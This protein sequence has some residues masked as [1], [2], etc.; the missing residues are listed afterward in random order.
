MAIGGCLVQRLL[1]LV[2]LLLAQADH[3]HYITASPVQSF[4][5]GYF[6]SG[7]IF[8]TASSSYQVQIVSE[9]FITSTTTVPL[10]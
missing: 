4:D 9:N 5:R 3:H 6:P 7:F 8:G 10:N 1:V 2:A